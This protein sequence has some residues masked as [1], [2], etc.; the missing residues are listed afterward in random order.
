MSVT[1][2]SVPNVLRVSFSQRETDFEQV[3]IICFVR[4]DGAGGLELNYSHHVSRTRPVSYGPWEHET[5]MR[6]SLTPALSTALDTGTMFELW[7]AFRSRTRILPA[8]PSCN[9]AEVSW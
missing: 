2:T 1:A 7:S 5:V 3:E 4:H 8:E 6:Q 9:L